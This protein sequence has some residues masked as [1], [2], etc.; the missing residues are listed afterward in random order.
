M[1]LLDPTDNETALSLIFALE[2]CDRQHTQICD[3][4][5]FVDDSMDA[6]KSDA[7]LKVKHAMEV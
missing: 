5:T 3:I 7:I 1:M 2:I 6:V 4:S